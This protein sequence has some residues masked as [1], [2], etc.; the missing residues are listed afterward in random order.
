M[1]RRYD[2]HSAC[3]VEVA[4]ELIGGKWKGVVL[5]HLLSGKKRFNEL[6]RLI[7]SVSQ[8]M[9]TRQL[10]ELEN[11]RLISRTV[12]PVVPPKVEYELTELGNSLKNLLQELRKWG[13]GPGEKILA[14]R[15][16]FE[17]TDLTGN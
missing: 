7:P 9:L 13:E 17:S 14:S 4:L 16:D 5:Y 3:S 2:C 10:R 1:K 12:Y 11:D 8:R 15:R 6:R